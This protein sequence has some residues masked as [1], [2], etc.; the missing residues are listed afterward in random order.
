MAV[1]RLL[2]LWLSLAAWLA[3]ANHCQFEAA[4]LIDSDHGETSSACCSPS[5][6]CARDAC[7]IIESGSYRASDESHALPAP[8]DA[9]L[10]CL[11]ALI[12]SDC[13]LDEIDSLTPPCHGRSA[14]ALRPVWHFVLRH[15]GNPRAPASLI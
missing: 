8:M 7:D 13:A 6:G 1:F 14:S 11:F 3:G 4:G 10:L 5:E 9:S 15:A 2:V 12:Q